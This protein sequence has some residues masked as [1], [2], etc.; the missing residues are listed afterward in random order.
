MPG[1]RLRLI[2]P[3]RTPHWR[4][5]PVL[6]T[7]A[8]LL[9]E[10]WAV[11]GMV[12]TV[13]RSALEAYP[14]AEQGAPVLLVP[15]FL[16]GDRSLGSLAAHLADAGYRPHPAAI[17]RNVD[18]SEA[19]TGHLTARLERLAAHHGGPV[20]VV[21][22]SR[23]GMLA[24]VLARRRPELVACVITL[25]SPHRDPLAVNPWLLAHALGLA[26]AGS[27]G[28]RGVVR[29]SCAA[30]ACCRGFRRDLAAAVPRGVGYLSVYSR[31]DGVVDWRA[32]LDPGGR[33]AEVYTGHCDM[34][35]DH[36]SLH[37]V[38]RTL[39]RLHAG[40]AARPGAL[41]QAA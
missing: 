30:G 14:R 9:R 40:A 38:A 28:L 22:H 23:G 36:V 19:A 1:P 32:C 39:D 41:A 34:T 3:Q 27:L 29:L 33:H 5:R 15:G 11:H 10:L 26:G 7:P 8:Q 37:L 6:P 17:A 18:C 31:R 24:R 4:P 13:G 2:S 25:G 35:R 16:A 12:R 20:A 21:G